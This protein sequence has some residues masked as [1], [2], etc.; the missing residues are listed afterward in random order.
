MLSQDVAICTARTF[1]G[2]QYVR[3]AESLSKVTA[4]FK[5]IFQEVESRVRGVMGCCP[6]LK[7]AT[8]DHCVSIPDDDYYRGLNYD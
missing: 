2:P 6:S 8:L 7:L 1:T 4:S 3:Q 5:K